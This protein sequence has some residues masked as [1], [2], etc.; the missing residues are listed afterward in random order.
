M[1]LRAFFAFEQFN[2]VPE[3]D[4]AAAQNIT[5][6][7]QLTAEFL[8]DFFEYAV[9]LAERVGVESGHDAT[10]PQIL[11]TNV[12]VTDAQAAAGPGAFCQA[13]DAAD[14]NVGAE[15]AAVVAKGRDCSICGDQE[16]KDIEPSPGLVAD[17]SRPGAGDLFGDSLHFCVAP[18]KAVDQGLAGC[19]KRSVIAEKLGMGARRDIVPVGA[20]EVDDAVAPDAQRSE[21]SLLQRLTG[22]GLNGKSP[23]LSNLHFGRTGH[24]RFTRRIG[25][26]VAGKV[27]IY[28]SRTG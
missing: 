27:A 7:G 13:I 21:R 25:C 12:N 5:I 6:Q 26:S 28:R 8:D 22:H 16:R 18:G 19:V 15:A 14:D 1:K 3:A 24:G 17:Q 11:D 4:L 20:L 2:R 10:A 9:V 23:K